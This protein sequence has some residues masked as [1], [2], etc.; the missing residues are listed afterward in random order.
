MPFIA[1]PGLTASCADVTLDTQSIMFYSLSST[2]HAPN[3]KF[4]RL[5][6]ALC[7]WRPLIRRLNCAIGACGY[8]DAVAIALC[9][10]DDRFAVDKGYGFLR[11]G[12]NAFT[13]TPAFFLINNKLHRTYLL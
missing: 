10:V 2:R 11:A 13:R 7:V 9:M 8:A 6:E 12:F 3:N 1:L 5:S 4:N